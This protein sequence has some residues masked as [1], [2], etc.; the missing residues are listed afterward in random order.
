MGAGDAGDAGDAGVGD[1]T[2]VIDGDAF[3][4]YGSRG[5]GDSAG[6]TPCCRCPVEEEVEAEGVTPSLT[7]R[8]EPPLGFFGSSFLSGISHVTAPTRASADKHPTVI[9]PASFDRGGGAAPLI[10][11]TDSSLPGK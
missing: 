8:C 9:F 10:A 7:L 1:A 5:V 3:A 2:A 6:T 11:Q 4:R